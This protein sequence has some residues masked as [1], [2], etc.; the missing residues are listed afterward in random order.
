[1]EI[2]Y[3]QTPKN[4]IKNKLM[5]IITKI[6]STDRSSIDYISMTSEEYADC[7]DY[8]NLT[9]YVFDIADTHSKLYGIPIKVEDK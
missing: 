1:M 7:R 9:Y 4:T 2:I 6:N 5:A 3:K 8:F